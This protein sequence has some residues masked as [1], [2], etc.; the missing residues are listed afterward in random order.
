MLTAGVGAFWSCLTSF[1]SSAGSVDI[2]LLLGFLN[3]S[4]TRSCG[5]V[6]DNG[7]RG[8]ACCTR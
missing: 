2:E 7:A 4:L 3:L 5:Q 1:L 6:K 8:Q